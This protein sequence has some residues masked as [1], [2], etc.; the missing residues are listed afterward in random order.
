LLAKRYTESSA[1]HQLYLKGRYAWNLRT[2]ESTAQAKSY[3][4]QAIAAD[5]S[6]ALAYAG[7]ADAHSLD[8][9]YR[10]APVSE[11]MRL[12]R[13][14]AERAIALDDD[15]AEAHTSLGWVNLIY[16]W[17]WERARIEFERALTLNPRYATARQ[18]Y[19]W[20]LVITNRLD[21]AIAE[22]RIARDLDPTSASIQRS[23]G[24]VHYYA[25]QPGPSLA[26]LERALGLN[27]TSDETLWI[28]GLSL[29]QLGRYDEAERALR[30]S[31]ANSRAYLHALA[32]LAALAA[33]RGQ[34]AE[35]RAILGEIETAARSHYVSP[36]D[37][38]RVYVALGDRGPAFE[39]MEL[40]Y[41][42][43]RGWLCYL[44]VDP[45]LDS[46]RDDPRF[47]ALA[48][49]MRFAGGA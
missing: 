22:A 46:V 3:F 42:E 28:M 18:W 21:E 47:R 12:A 11:G 4:E 45:A 6:Y 9:D 43:R 33:I 31:H 41:A 17:D 40:A 1:A 5:P 13:I 27:P 24:W 2:P 35:A 29:V 7:L 20:Y 39:F 19:A 49:R 10:A 34:S 36:V 44:N 26:E 48:A 8:I 16:D 14:N 23:L 32:S 38:V 25:R 37:F 30:E 15:L